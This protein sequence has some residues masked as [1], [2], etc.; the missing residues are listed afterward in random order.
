MIIASFIVKIKCDQV[1]DIYN[2]YVIKC[3]MPGASPQEMLHPGQLLLSLLDHRAG[4]VTATRP[5]TAFDFVDLEASL[6]SD[7]LASTFAHYGSASDPTCNVWSP[8]CPAQPFPTAE[9]RGCQEFGP[10]PLFSS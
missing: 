1:Y 3:A 4:A 9:R 8:P 6:C 2:K 5:V 10:W 7:S